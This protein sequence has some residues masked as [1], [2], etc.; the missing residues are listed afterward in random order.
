MDARLR[1]SVGS[2]C[3][4]CGIG[5]VRVARSRH[6]VTKRSRNR[7]RDRS[8]SGEE[9]AMSELD[10]FLVTVVTAVAIWVVQSAQWN[11]RDSRR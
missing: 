3:R 1:V 9:Q 10:I 5:A 7:H 8:D 11:R 6:P 2:S 4:V